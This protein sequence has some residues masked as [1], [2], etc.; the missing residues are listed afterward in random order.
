MYEIFGL[1]EWCFYRRYRYKMDLWYIISKSACVQFVSLLYFSKDTLHNMYICFATLILW[2]A[3]FAM[4]TL[5]YQN[6]TLLVPI[7]YI[8]C[9]CTL[10]HFQGVTLLAVFLHCLIDELHYLYSY[11]ISKRCSEKLSRTCLPC[12]LKFRSSAFRMLKST[13]AHFVC[14]SSTLVY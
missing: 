10:F 3:T 9:I 4:F 11:I 1:P 12:L 7:S 5:T 2:G 13:L 6:I 14:W 8:I